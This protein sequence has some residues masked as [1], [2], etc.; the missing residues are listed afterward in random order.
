MIRNY[1]K[2]AWRNLV[3]NKMF[4]LIN[5]LGISIGL[6]ASLLILEYVSFELSYDSFNKN[7]M[8]IYRV[9]NDRY[10][11]G[12]FIQH[13]TMTYS[14]VSKAMRTDFPEIVDYTRVEQG[15]Q[16]VIVYDGKKFEGQQEFAVENSF[17]SMLSY[18]LLAGNPNSA[19]VAPHSVVITQSLAKK[20]FNVADNSVAS[21]LGKSISLG[22][23]PDL[24]NITG[25]CQDIPENSH[26]KF[27]FLVSYSTLYSGKHSW[28][29]ADYDFTLSKF[30]HYIRLK[31]GTNYKDLEAKLPD[32]SMR[33]FHG[34]MVSGSVEKFYLQPLLRAHLYSDFMYEIG[35]TA[36]ATVVWGLFV[37]ALLILIIAWVNYVNLATAK[38]MER[39]K[40]VGVRKVAGASKHQLVGQF[41]T[42][43]FII[44]IFS[45][46]IAIIIIELAQGS[47]NTLV[48][49][50]LSF[51]FLF[52]KSL[53]G[54][55]F[56]ALMFIFVLLGIVISGFYPS[57]V[58][59]SFKP[60]TVLN[61][62][63][64]NTQTGIGL[65][66]ILVTVQFTI[67]VALTICS[68]VVYKQLHYL[69]KE[70]LGLNMS[71]ILVI[72]NVEFTNWDSTLLTK[73]NTFL[74]E[75]KKIPG[76][77]GGA[78]SWKLPGDELDRNF[79][80]QRNDEPSLGHF[81]ITYNGI[82]PDFIS[83]YQ[84]KMLAGR[85]FVNTDYNTEGIGLHNLIPNLSAIKML[86]FK[87]P[88]N[89]IG[90]QVTLGN[91]IYNIIGVVSD[92][93][94][95]SLHYPVQPTVF[96][97]A[98]ASP[99][100]PFSIKIE[101]RHVRETINAI[102]QKYDAIFPMNLFDYF[103]IDQK[104]NQQYSSDQLLGKVFVIFSG[105]SI[106][107]ACLGL[108]GLSLLT[109]FQRTKEIGVRKVLGASLGNIVYVLSK[110]FIRLVLLAV[111]IAIPIAWYVMNSWLQNF[112]SRTNLSWLIFIGSGLLA[113]I[114]ALV[115]IFFQSVKAALA[116][117]V[118]WLRSE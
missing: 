50:Q 95:K 115:T 92:F 38:S 68:L 21:V 76:V 77:L 42:E 18:H 39:A 85:T 64:I 83:I 19:L 1:I 80:I 81:T 31:P 65:R 99:H 12:K 84:M 20:I 60:V 3:K 112:V 9:Y 13:S 111:V 109:T 17:L 100:S 106:F 25:V 86:E 5:V 48:N 51:A 108:S 104:F 54:Y 59:S 74:I 87:S 61:G 23:D 62:K 14:A 15:G 63:F 118:K 11:N 24:L 72:K 70:S 4:S 40:E 105:L 90:R 44:N 101:A 6:A 117:P 103:F 114:I 96:F 10:Q 37:I 55:S 67:A 94:Q 32:F 43:S 69:S 110:D 107:I 98:S 49:H 28:A 22:T 8:D 73:Q 36:S 7:A 27:D 88:S 53:G 57:F 116:N 102:K 97:P 30:W 58:L 52:H 71:Q 56:S 47:F 78:F 29:Q 82:S 75:I 66:K 35:V 46:C 16:K 41:M 45:L 33:H 91:V 113:T 89:A 34:S 79:D 26:L 2:T 93:H